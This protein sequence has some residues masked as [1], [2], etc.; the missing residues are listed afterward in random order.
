M[1]ASQW[2]FLAITQMSSASVSFIA[3]SVTAVMI[4]RSQTSCGESSLKSSP[5]H[6]IIFGLSVSD[7][8]QSFAL[9]TGPFA[10]PAP[11]PQA[12]WGV[13]NSMSCSAN[14]FLLSFGSTATPMYILMLCAYC[15]FSTIKNFS[16][17]KGFPKQLEWKM[18]AFI[19]AINLCLSVAG[20]VTKTFNTFMSGTSCGFGAHPSG[21]RQ[22]PDIFGECEEDIERYAN[23][24]I[25]ITWFFIPVVCLVGIVVTMS[26]TC[27]HVLQRNSIFSS[28]ARNPQSAQSAQISTLRKK[29]DKGKNQSKFPT[30][31]GA[32]HACPA[33]LP[34]EKPPNDISRDNTKNK[35]DGDI[36]HQI[37]NTPHDEEADDAPKV[38]VNTEALMKTFAREFVVQACMFV[39]SFLATFIFWWVALIMLVLQQ[40]SPPLFMYVLVVFFYPL[41]G[42]LNILVYTRP[43]V[44]SFYRKYGRRRYSWLRA[45]LLVV[46][47]GGVVPL[48]IQEDMKEEISTSGILRDGSLDFKGKS[49]SL[50]EP[51]CFKNSYIESNV[52]CDYNGSQSFGNDN[53]GYRQKEDWSCQLGAASGQVSNGD[54]REDSRFNGSEVD[55]NNQSMKPFIDAK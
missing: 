26:M 51:K 45:F 29:G 42:F 23:I 34:L 14:G 39:A 31:N 47:A 38:T 21:C 53:I 10:A 22:H 11:V 32:N 13:G 24:F 35:N 18:H 44:K 4:L 50:Q 1:S 6:R 8:L 54:F 17:Y 48:E 30:E 33:P 16:N 37:K 28:L 9:I 52:N 55:P 27:W 7:L 36:I 46:K 41:G 43:K 19:I 2:K 5:Y 15:L 40:K 25:F 49:A 20:L 3:S 12:L